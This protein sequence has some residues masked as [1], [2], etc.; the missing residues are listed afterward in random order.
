MHYYAIFANA[1]LIFFVS[2]AIIGYST[3]NELY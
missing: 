1:I 3:F 2:F